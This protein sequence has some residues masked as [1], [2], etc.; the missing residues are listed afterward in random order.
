[1]KPLRS[2]GKPQPRMTVSSFSEAAS[3]TLPAL[4]CLPSPFSAARFLL[5]LRGHATS[6]IIAVLKVVRVVHAPRMWWG[7]LALPDVARGRKGHAHGH[8]QAEGG[9]R[10]WPGGLSCQGRH[11]QCEQGK[12]PSGAG[13]NQLPAP[14]KI[15]ATEGRIGLPAD[16]SLPKTSCP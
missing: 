3:L 9:G 2:L 4:W 1:M 11:L 7:L 14:L 8:A 6:P 12:K 15:P 16:F 13:G 5:P 10:S